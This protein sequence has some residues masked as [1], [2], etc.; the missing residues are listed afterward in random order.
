MKKLISSILALCMALSL[1]VAPASAL[2]L[3]DAKQLLAVHYVDGVPPEVL[4]L[5]SLDAI[6]EALGDPYT[7]YMTP[8]QYQAFNQS[9]NG[10]TVVGIGATVETAYDNGGYRIMSVLPDSP[11]LEAGIQPGDILTAADG[12]PMSPEVDP[13]VPIVGEEGTP[14]TLTLS[15]NGQILEFSLVRRAVSIPIVT[16]DQVGSA[17][18]VEITLEDILTD[19]VAADKIPYAGTNEDGR[20]DLLLLKNVTGDAYTYG[21][22]RS[23][24]ASSGREGS[25]DYASWK[26]V[27]IENGSGISAYC[28]SI[29]SVQEE[30]G[31]LAVTAGGKIAGFQRLTKVTDVAR[32]A[33][34]GEDYVVLEGV[35]VPISAS[36]QVYNEDNGT[37]IDLTGA[38]GYAD[39]LTVYYSGVL[40]GNAKVRVVTVGE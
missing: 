29:E 38:K 37:W 31:G 20:V 4:E 14:L 36:V 25:E 16:Y 32:S 18:V 27:A 17:P 3:E 34:D 11:A 23:A 5:D 39:T 26:T 28:A 7:F 19:T 40:G 2:T 6:L 10:R 30:F 22:Y 33:F 9:V 15:R 13:R 21:R 1:T 8:E 35:R 24:T 12:V